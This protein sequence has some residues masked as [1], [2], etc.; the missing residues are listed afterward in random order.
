MPSGSDRL[1]ET[2]WPL[3][4]A[5]TG[6]GAVSNIL[7]AAS[8][9]PFVAVSADIACAGEKPIDVSL[10][11][12]SEL[13]ASGSGSGSDMRFISIDSGATTLTSTCAAFI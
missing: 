7:R 3:S 4:P 8:T 5:G 2:S 6:A 9:S 13:F 12:F 1:N 10:D 11:I